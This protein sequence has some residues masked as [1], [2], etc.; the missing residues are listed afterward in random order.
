MLSHSEI[1]IFSGKPK[2]LLTLLFAVS[3]QLSFG[4]EYHKLVDTNKLWNYYDC[5]AGPQPHYTTLYRFISDTLID[6]IKYYIPEITN[7]SGNWYK[8]NYYLR[9]EDS[10]KR[11]YILCNNNE[12]LIYDFS[13]NTGDSV[14]ILN[15]LYTS[16]SP[17]TIHV[18][19]VDSIKIIDNSY[20]KIIN[21][22]FC[23][24]IEGIGDKMG[25]CHPGDLSAGN[26]ISLVCY[27]ENDS[28]KYLSPDYDSCFYSFVNINEN[29][30]EKQVLLKD[31]G[32]N[33]YIIQTKSSIEEVKIYNVLGEKMRK[34]NPFS[35]QCKINMSSFSSGIYFI[36]GKTSNKLFNI[37]IVKP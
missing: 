4:Q 3:M 17:I 30:N 26:C 12:G 37:K 21:S 25:L 20:R 1:P 34:Y 28:L 13:L 32:N 11:V 24:W 16:N 33:S 23:T 35:N 29:E 27:Y 9:E 8:Q 31:M 19:S 5:Y 22:D 15:T 2:I 36:T 7:D 18:I 6:E 10:T 14:T